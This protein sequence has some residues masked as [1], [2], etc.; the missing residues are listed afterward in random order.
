MDEFNRPNSDIF[1]YLLTTRAGVSR[2]VELF[3]TL[4]N[5]AKIRALE[6]TFS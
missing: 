6:L 3:F 4:V 1:I 2:N 5:E